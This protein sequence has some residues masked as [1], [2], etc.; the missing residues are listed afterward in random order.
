M[1][2]NSGLP[3]GPWPAYSSTEFGCPETSKPK[4]QL[5][6]TC[7]EKV[8]DAVMKQKMSNPIGSKMVYSDL[9]MIIMNFVVGHFAKKLGYVK[10]NELFPGCLQP[11]SKRG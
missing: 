11:N 1:L 9:S 6:F 2:H 3:A 8:F 4:P 7:Q 5:V 10:E